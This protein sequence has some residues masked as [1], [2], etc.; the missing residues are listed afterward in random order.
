MCRSH[1]ASVHSSQK[2]HLLNRLFYYPDWVLSV[3][4]FSVLLSLL[5][6]VYSSCWK[7][8]TCICVFCTF[9]SVQVLSVRF[10]QYPFT[11]PTNCWWWWNSY[12]R[13]QKKIKH[14]LLKIIL[15]TANLVAC[16]YKQIVGIFCVQKRLER[17]YIKINSRSHETNN[18]KH[19]RIHQVSTLSSDTKLMKKVHSI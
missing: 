19:C 16:I 15:I 12:T 1:Y 2:L 8:L 10:V 13:G 9:L 17:P 3:V 6:Y 7:R 5:A 18:R 4:V 14:L 11:P